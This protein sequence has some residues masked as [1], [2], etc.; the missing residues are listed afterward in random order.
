MTIKSDIMNEPKPRENGYQ[1]RTLTGLRELACWS[2]GWAAATLLMKNGPLVLWNKDLTFTLLAVGVD[3]AVGVGLILAHKN[4]LAEL[5]ELQKKVY[6]DALGITLGVTV[7]AGVA[8]EFL[9]KYDV[10]PFHFSNLLILTCVT[11]LASVLYGTWRY[12]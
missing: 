7:T 4:W 8:Y 6:L 5:D 2:A 3:L 1:S 11:L 10:I 12:R 9:D